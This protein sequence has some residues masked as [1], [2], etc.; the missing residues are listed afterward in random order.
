MKQRYYLHV[1][2]F[3]AIFFWQGVCAQYLLND[4]GF[5]Q[6]AIFSTRSQYMKALGADSYL[7]NG[8]AYERYWN[9][10]TG[11]PFFLAEQFQKDTL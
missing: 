5:H 7:Y 2:G 10:V 6:K 1:T 11:H 3:V 8:T 4:S 9:G